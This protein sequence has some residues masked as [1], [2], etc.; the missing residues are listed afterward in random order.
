MEPY[1]LDRNFHKRDIIDGFNSII[2]TERYYGNSEVELVVPINPDML[3]A[4]SLGVFL[5][6]P[7]SDEIMILETVNIEDN[8]LKLNGISLLPWLNNRFIRIDPKHDVV[9]WTLGVNAG[10]TPGWMLWAMVYYMCCAGSL[11][12]NGTNPTGIPNPEQLIIPGLGLKDYD[13]SGTNVKTVIPYGPLY[14]RMKE[15]AEAYEI[16]MQI[17]LDAVT[18]TSYSLGF[19][20]YKGLDRTSNQT[21]YPPVRFSPQMDSLTNIK[22]LQSIAALKTLVYTYSEGFTEKDNPG[23]MTKLGEARLT[24]LQYTGF[25]LRAL[26]LPESLTV[27]M[28]GGRTATSGPPPV[29][30]LPGDPTQVI[31]VLNLFAAQALNENSGIAVVDGE[32]VPTNQFKY[33]IHYNL[34]DIIEVQGNSPVVSPSRV[35]EYIRAQ[36]EAGERA[37][38]TVTGLDKV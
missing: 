15:I 22:E 25:D 14:D 27:D 17:T 23:L 36:D 16:G 34:G 3:N 11:Y 33:G 10:E 35:T 30:A 6:I 5:G 21:T 19:R 26:M 4:L 9:S 12:L 28:V 7:E 32:I 38:P 13:K 2:W 8:K 37:Y 1:T 31:Q 18:D 24:G 20:S 29:T